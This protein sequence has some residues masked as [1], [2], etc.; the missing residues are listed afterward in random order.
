M[1]NEITTVIGVILVILLPFFIFGLVLRLLDKNG[2]V[3]EQI[4]SFWSVGD[5]IL[6]LFC[7]VQEGLRSLWND[8]EKLVLSLTLGLMVVAV[9][10]PPWRIAWRQQSFSQGFAFLLMPP[11]STAYIDLT[12]LIVELLLIGLVGGLV[13]VFIRGSRN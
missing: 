12:F 3:R 2:W 13:W 10:F 9:T 11:A 7:K 1:W 4:P 6:I 5:D 8:R